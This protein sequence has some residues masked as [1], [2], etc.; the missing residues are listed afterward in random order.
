[1]KDEDLDY[2]VGRFVDAALNVVDEALR[3]EGY[4]LAEGRDLRQRLKEAGYDPVKAIWA[5]PEILDH[6]ERLR[7][8]TGASSRLDFKEDKTLSWVSYE[9]SEVD[10]LQ[11][12]IRRETSE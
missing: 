8:F 12:S 10:K 9:T 11:K 5:L 3:E 2:V 6:L 1:M 7:R 4:E